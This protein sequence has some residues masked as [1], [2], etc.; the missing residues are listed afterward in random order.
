MSKKY[1]V[2]IAFSFL[3]S[4]LSA[5]PPERFPR[6]FVGAYIGPNLSGFTGHYVGNIAGQTGKIRIRTQYG[7]YGKIFINRDYSV[8]TAIELV[9][10]GAMTK[11]KDASSATVSVS[12]IAKTNLNTFSIPALFTFTPKEYLGLLIGPQFDY[13]LSANEPWNRSDVNMP[14]DYQEDVLYKYNRAGVSLALGGYYMLL[15]GTTMHLRY[16]QGLSNMTKAEYGNAKPYTIQFYLGINI[17]K[18]S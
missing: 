10:N 12:Y 16:T 13:I 17:Y 5:Q 18:K 4:M 7:F 2:L 11:D 9:L 15:N 3:F 1:S 6:T 8:F 14:E